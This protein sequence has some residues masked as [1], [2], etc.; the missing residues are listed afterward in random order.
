MFLVC[1][2]WMITKHAVIR[3][4]IRLTKLQGFYPGHLSINIIYE[5]TVEG[6]PAH[7]LLVDMYLSRARS[8]WLVANEAPAFLYDLA[9]ALLEKTELP[10]CAW[11]LA[12][13]LTGGCQLPDLDIVCEFPSHEIYRIC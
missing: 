3:E 1:D 12:Q 11:R 6:D 13:R 7:R 9:Q 4:I 10:P 5:G 8:K 2:S